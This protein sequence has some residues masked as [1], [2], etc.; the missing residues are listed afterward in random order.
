MSGGIDRPDWGSE[1]DEAF[2]PDPP[3]EAQQRQAVAKAEKAERYPDWPLVEEPETPQY[4]ATEFPDEAARIRQLDAELEAEVEADERAEGHTVMVSDATLPADLAIAWDSDPAG[5]EYRLAEAQS[6]ALV[7]LNELDADDRQLAES[8][9]HDMPETVQ[10][11]LLTELGLGGGGSCKSATE[12]ELD[13]F[14]GSDE[15]AEL[16]DFWK[17]R[18]SKNLG[19]VH[20]RIKRIVGGLSASEQKAAWKFFDDLPSRGKIAAL[21]VLAG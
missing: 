4:L 15:G 16:V 14:S 5:A 21:C 1:P 12:D 11:A 13:T 9:F 3:T 6:S 17:G 7:V 10:S 19:M 18:A 8:S 2:V 20:Q